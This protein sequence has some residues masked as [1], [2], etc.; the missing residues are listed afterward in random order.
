MCSRI[1]PVL[2]KFATNRQLFDWNLRMN[3]AFVPLHSCGRSILGRLP[4]ITSKLILGPALIGLILAELPVWQKLA[5]CQHGDDWLQRGWL[6]G[7]S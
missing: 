4:P 1:A 5:L 6:G 2:C 7:R 3:G